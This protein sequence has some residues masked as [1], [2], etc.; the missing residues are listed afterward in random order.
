MEATMTAP[1]FLLAAILAATLLT[2]PVF[3]AEE[4]ERC[5]SDLANS[6]IYRSMPTLDQLKKQL[7]I[8]GKA[9]LIQRI[10]EARQKFWET[11][12]G[13]PDN[14]APVTDPAKK[15]RDSF[16]DLLSWKDI[17]FLELALRW[18]QTRDL[19]ERRGPGFATKVQDFLNGLLPTDG[20]IR[21]AASPEFFDWVEA[22]RKGFGPEPKNFDEIFKQSFNIA[23]MGD[24]F[25]KAVAA[26]RTQYLAY[27]TERDWWEFDARNRIPPRFDTREGYA[28]YLYARYNKLPIQDACGNSSDMLAALENNDVV[29]ASA[30]LVRKAAKTPGGLLVVTVPPPMKLTPSGQKVEDPTVP[31]P[32]GVI[33]V[34]SD[35]VRAFEILA[36]K[37]DDIRYL[38]WLLTEQNMPDGRYFYVAHK[39]DFANKT[40][41]QLVEAFGLNDVREAAR[42]V[43]TAKKRMTSNTV[44]DQNA[45]GA[46][47]NDPFEA[48]EDILARNNA[49][50]NN[51]KGYV[52]MAL[53]LNQGLPGGKGKIN[54]AYEKYVSSHNEKAFLDAAGRVAAGKPQLTYKNEIENIEREVKSP[55]TAALQPSIDVESSLYLPWKGFPAGSKASYIWRGLQPPKPGSTNFIPGR[56]EIRSSY[57]LPTINNEHADVWFSEIVYDYPSGQAHP[58]HETEWDYPARNRIKPVDSQKPPPVP[59]QS[60]EQILTFGGKSLQTHWESVRP[61]PNCPDFVISTWTSVEV[62]GELVRKV[63]DINNCHGYRHVSETLLESFQGS[64]SQA[65]LDEA[66]KRRAAAAPP[67]STKSSSA[68]F[69]V[70]SS[71]TQTAGTPAGGAVQQMPVARQSV[72]N[73]LPSA[74]TPPPLTR[75]LPPSGSAASARPSLGVTV[76]QGS[77]LIVHLAREVD[78]SISKPGSSFFGSLDQPLV[79]NGVQIA[80]R[81]TPI[82]AQLVQ[83]PNGAGLTLCLT[84]ITVA[85]RKYALAT[86]QVTASSNPTAQSDAAAAALN[87]ILAAAGPQAA[88]TAR[89]RLARQA[90]TRQVLL[91]GARIYVPPMAPLAFTLAA[92]L[93]L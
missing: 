92:P 42:R 8:D 18:P 33:G 51:A 46:T 83:M 69:P 25:W 3:A 53:A 54:A 56:T 16:A 75:T 91:N 19:T 57:S 87:Q 35:P 6:L 84:D 11:Y 50:R 65:A 26:S 4:Q 9:G 29:F 81:G 1:R 7:P 28:I 52:R 22:V 32:E 34:Y 60:G 39:W 61:Q 71:A 59:T 5:K 43:R 68:P 77:V 38:K 37:D 15:A 48:F 47:R 14:D 78:S 93:V 80:Q 74:A 23:L 41:A 17:Y 64:R 21:Q 44:M 66:A 49:T 31:M 89:A 27:V 2:L 86:S 24:T 55:T 45:I 67:D 10:V 70:E 79:I 36:T 12:T 58:P 73:T 76:P 72:G 62:P 88:A 82:N 13:K 63:E 30:D 85:G 90:N 40:Y 20:G